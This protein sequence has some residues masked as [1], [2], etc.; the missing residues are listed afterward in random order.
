MLDDYFLGF[1][2]LSSDLAWEQFAAFALEAPIWR[3]VGQ[4]DAFHAEIRRY[5]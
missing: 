5:V 1:S 3:A 4:A 2:H